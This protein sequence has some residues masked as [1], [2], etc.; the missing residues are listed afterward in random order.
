MKFLI[1]FYP[2]WKHPPGGEFHV[3]IQGRREV[4]AKIQKIQST[5]ISSPL[6]AWEQCLSLNSSC[7]NILK[8]S[9]QPLYGD[10][11]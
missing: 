10:I 2:A 4:R 7:I 11:L 9:T 1:N 6:H 3:L 5:W 8:G